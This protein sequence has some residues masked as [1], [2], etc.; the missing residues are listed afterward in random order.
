MGCEAVSMES[1]DELRML[2]IRQS[3]GEVVART[4]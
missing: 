2:A 3:L 1:T 4:S